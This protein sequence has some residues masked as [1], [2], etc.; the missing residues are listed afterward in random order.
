MPKDNRNITGKLLPDEGGAYFLV[1]RLTKPRTI[2]VGK[3]GRFSFAH[4][5]YL[6]C[7]SAKKGIRARVVRHLRQKNKRLHW[8]IDY[9]L[10]DPAAEVITTHA[11]VNR[12][13]CE[14]VKVLIT[15][16]GKPH[17]LGFGASDCRA[18]CRSH[19]VFFNSIGKVNMAISQLADC[20]EA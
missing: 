19:L 6:Y 7:G 15:C 4:G 12:E 8:H 2:T 20:S 5:Y 11:F 1:I 16:G 3:L 18:G 10:A 17:P 14:L 9:L 13:E